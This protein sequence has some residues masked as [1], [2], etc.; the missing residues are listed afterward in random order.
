MSASM[1]RSAGLLVMAA[2]MA[3]AATLFT[4]QDARAQGTRMLVVRP[5]RRRTSRRSAR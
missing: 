1:Y 2:A 4:A 5:R 3:G